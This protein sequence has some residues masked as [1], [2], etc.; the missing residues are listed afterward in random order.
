MCNLFDLPGTGFADD[1]QHKLEVLRSHCEDAG[2]DYG[3]IEKTVSTF[4][5]PHED[6]DSVLDHFIELAD[7][8]IDQA[9]VSPR[10]PWDEATLD[11]VA[12]RWCPTFMRF[13]LANRRCRP[14]S[15]RNPSWTFERFSFDRLG[16]PDGGSPPRRQRRGL[17]IRPY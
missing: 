17:P 13:R 4:V 14:R 8:G 10:G 11:W 7:L 5:D 3:A 6:P 12:A 16:Q 15:A 2:R 9:M 1:L